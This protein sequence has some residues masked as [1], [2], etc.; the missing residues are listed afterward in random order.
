MASAFVIYV[1]GAFSAI[2]TLVFTV[3]NG[4]CYVPLRDSSVTTRSIG[5][6]LICLSAVAC[7]L[8]IV[9]TLLL[10]K[11][12][13]AGRARWTPWKTGT[14]AFVTSYH[15]ITAG[16]VAGTIPE[17]DP[18]LM[19][20]SRVA[21]SSETH[22]LLTARLVVWAVS[23][24]GQG[25]LCGSLLVPFFTEEPNKSWAGQVSRD[26]DS[27]HFTTYSSPWSNS[28][29]QPILPPLRPKTSMGKSISSFSEAPSQVSNRYSGLT[30]LQPDT[31]GNASAEKPMY[32]NQRFSDSSSVRP[33]VSDNIGRSRSPPR[34][35]LK[36]TSSL[37]NLVRQTLPETPTSPTSANTEPLRTT[38]GQE[39][40]Q[41]ENDIHPLFRPSSPSPPP[42]PTCG[43]KVTAAP[44]A[45]QTITAGTLEWMRSSSQLGARS[46][47][48]RSSTLDYQPRFLFESEDEDHSQR[49][50]ENLGRK[51]SVPR[52]IL[53][54]N[55]RESKIRYEKKKQSG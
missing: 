24:F 27:S 36:I 22:V 32:S 2:S 28:D 13:S 52:F 8:L 18:R 40:T 49:P 45:G 39:E 51:P 12:F 1:L 34:N 54:A 20:D 50:K 48:S 38:F 41:K 14:F 4:V 35:H 5:L 37:D 6:A 3:L 29:P 53:K 11:E 23:V 19:R 26:T 44:V 25:L 7:A 15:L 21:V 55:V 16:F 43:T 31:S 9:L 42:T 46:N 30:L 17:S 10:R 47:R 33:A